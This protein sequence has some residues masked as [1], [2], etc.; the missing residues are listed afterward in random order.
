MI[1]KRAIGKRTE[2]QRV[3]GL[4]V[5]EGE[6]LAFSY[7][8]KRIPSICYKEQVFVANS[9]NSLLD[10]ETFATVGQAGMGRVWQLAIQPKPTHGAML[11]S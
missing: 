11:H 10:F 6:G 7:Y 8:L 1:V 3:I 4:D 5:E 2:R 9:I